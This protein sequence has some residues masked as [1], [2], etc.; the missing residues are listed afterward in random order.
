M[1]HRLLRVIAV[2]LAFCFAAAGQSQTM[3]VDKLIAFIQSSAKFIQ[4]KTITD[5]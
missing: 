3:S 4:A 5:T 2:C 1:P